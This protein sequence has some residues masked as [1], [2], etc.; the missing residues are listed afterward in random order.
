[1]SKRLTKQELEEA[2]AEKEVEY[3]RLKKLNDEL[4][5]ELELFKKKYSSL[6]KEAQEW[7]NKY[8]YNLADYDNLRKR[9]RKELEDG[10]RYANEK[11][12]LELLKVVDNY[13]RAIKSFED[14]DD[15][16]AIKEGIEMIHKSFVDFLKKEGV[17]AFSSKGAKF[18][19]NRHE[20][21]TVVETD[22]SPPETVVDEFEKG[23]IYK[24]K[25]LRPAKV[26]VSKEKSEKKEVVED[27]RTDNRNRSGNV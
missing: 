4:K 10:I 27:E 2:L 12:L 16:N 19:P 25:I 18:D 5:R 21:F 6:E 17:V 13:E 14:S 26:A 23:Y 11:F 8:L 15:I 1:M 7:K 20:A 22:D 24:N 9:T 3:Q